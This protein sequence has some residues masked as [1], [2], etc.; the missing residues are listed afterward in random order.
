MAGKD[1]LMRPDGSAAPVIRMA[2]TTGGRR[3]HHVAT[4]REPAA[5]FSGHLIIVNGIVCGDYALQVSD[6]DSIRPQIMAN[7]HADLPE[8]GTEDYARHHQLS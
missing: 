3:V 4:S 2:A 8:F 5:E 6:L 7:G 1:M